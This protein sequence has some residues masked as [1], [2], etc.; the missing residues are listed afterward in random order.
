MNM[1]S[2]KQPKIMHII[3]SFAA[4]SLFSVSTLC[5]NL[6]DYKYIIVHGK[7]EDTPS[8]F[9]KLFP[10]GTEFVHWKSVQREINIIRDIKAFRELTAILRKFKDVDVIHLHSSKA[11][12][13]GRLSA[14]YLN[15]QQKIVYTAR[16]ASFL[17]KDVSPIKK[18]VFILAEWFASKL[19]GNVIGCS[20]S[21]TK[22]FKKYKIN[23][24]CIPNAIPLEYAEPHF[25]ENPPYVV[26][27]IGR[28]SHAKNPEMFAQVAKHFEN[29]DNI[30]FIWVG[31]GEL[32]DKLENAN[33]TV[34]GWCDEER[35]KHY[36]KQ[37]DIYLSTSLWEGLPISVLEAMNHYKPLILSDCVG[38]IDLVIPEYNGYI[39]RKPEEAVDYIHKL[40]QDKMLRHTLGKN[41]RKL[42]EEK[43][44]L[45]QMINKYSE[46]YQKIMVQNRRKRK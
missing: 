5:N 40:L 39:Y 37:I 21:E 24:I 36:L 43:F 35:V 23:A 29:S 2:A 1:G 32:R 45:T 27:T 28:I 31:D 22:E 12:F 8:D 44:N 25:N 6:P 17:R 30:K 14:K 20:E 3:E 4:G 11:G 10:A 15:I 38:N 33:I 18:A 34:T 41:S 46:L 13:L 19:G 42:L 26:G 7:R 9:K 16:G